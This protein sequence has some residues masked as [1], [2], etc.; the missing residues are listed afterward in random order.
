MREVGF[1]SSFSFV[2]SD[3][4]HTKAALL[5]G[6]VER[7]VALDRLSRLQAWQNQASDRVLAS[8]RGEECVILLEGKSRRDAMPDRDAPAH[9]G[10]EKALFGLF[11]GEESWQGKTAQGFLV[12]VTIP[13]VRKDRD[14]WRGAM[15]PVRIEA[16]AR[17]S[18]KGRQA[19]APW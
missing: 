16:A 13:P 3:R 6:K 9:P 5:P 1:A 7:A 18:L 15:L 19:G 10:G 11:P 12:N 14:G 8:M 4:P 2:Y 17:H